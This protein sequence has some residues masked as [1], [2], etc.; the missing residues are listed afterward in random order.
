MGTSEIKPLITGG[1]FYEAE[2]NYMIETAALL[3]M[4]DQDEVVV[5]EPKT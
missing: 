4:T 1:P 2:R 5:D 3:G